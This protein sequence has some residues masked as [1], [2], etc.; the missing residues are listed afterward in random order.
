M[1]FTMKVKT[2]MTPNSLICCPGCERELFYVIPS[3][4]F[5]RAY[6]SIKDDKNRYDELHVECE[7]CGCEVAISL[8]QDEEIGTEAK[9]I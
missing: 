1:I 4:G 8:R 9:T 2:N 5:R 6:L 7:E 3:L